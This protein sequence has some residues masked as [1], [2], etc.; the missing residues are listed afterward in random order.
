MSHIDSSRRK[1]V[2]A[3]VLVLLLACLGVAACGSSSKS[4]STSANAAAT[5]PSGAS[6]TSTGA[7]GQG[8][9]GQGAARFKAMRECLQ[10]N[11]ITLPQRTPGQRPRGGPGGAGGFLG[12]GGAGPQ[13]PKGVTRAQYEAAIKKCGGG[14]FAGRGARVNSPA[15]KQ[16]LAKFATCMRENGVNVPT[17]NTS[18]KGPVFDTKGLNTTSSQFRTAESKCSSDLRSSFRRGSGTG[19]PPSGAPPSGASSGGGAAPG[20]EAAGGGSATG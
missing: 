13:L 12:G 10:K 7:G 18:G 15:F 2:A 8:A 14:S 11:G 9:T 1:P 3:I 20:G 17:P 19:A 6:G 4:S 16:A 5:S